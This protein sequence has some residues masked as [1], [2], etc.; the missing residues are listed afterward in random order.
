M[1]FLSKKIFIFTNTEYRSRRSSDQI[2][3]PEEL[4]QL[5]LHR[6]AIIIGSDEK[7]IGYFIA[8]DSENR[9]FILKDGTNNKIYPV[10]TITL[11]FF[12]WSPYSLMFYAG[13]EL[14]HNNE[15]RRR[16]INMMRKMPTLSDMSPL[17]TSPLV[18][19]TEHEQ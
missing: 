5:I 14:K 8:L 7:L 9:A 13:S 17:S 19:A 6:H 2:R 16:Y 15:I 18:I 11:D 12:A 3:T 1:R 4:E 10:L